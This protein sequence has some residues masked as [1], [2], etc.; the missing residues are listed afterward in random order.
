MQMPCPETLC[1]AGGLGR[2]PRGKKWYEEH[3]LRETARSIAK[4]QTQYIERLLESGCRILGIVGV[5]F[6][7]ACAVSY[8]NKGHSI[9]QGTGIYME[10]L[11]A[12]LE[13]AR[14]KIPMIGISQRWG[15][16]MRHDLESLLTDKK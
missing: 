13:A 5:E 16:K 2:V 7:P 14:V 6:S 10:E 1:P 3:G 9:Q 11:K 12:A 8:L 15:N 4:G